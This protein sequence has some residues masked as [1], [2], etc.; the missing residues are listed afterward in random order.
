MKQAGIFFGIVADI[1][2]TT[3]NQSSKYIQLWMKDHKELFY[4]IIFILILIIIF[5]IY[6]KYINSKLQKEKKEKEILLEK[7][8][9][10]AYYDVLTNI[11]NRLSVMQ[12]FEQ[13]LANAQR[14]NLNIAVMFIDLDGFKTI[15]DTL[16]HEAGDRVLKDVADIFK[17]TLRKNDLY[18]RL[19]GDEF[20]VVA[21]GIEGKENI[22][23]LV[24]K[25]LDKINAIPLPSPLNEQFGASI[26]VV[27]INPCKDTTVE[28]LMSESDELMY[29]I[30]RQGKNSYKIKFLKC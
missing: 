9:K 5:L 24:R 28:K 7:I 25:L 19:G 1:L 17:S 3:L 22:E 20:I 14:N 2:V 29:D 18:G 12:S 30:K 16:G 23:K 10:L 26:G 27:C 21:Q 13:I 6:G 11:P 8:K 15:N 4:A